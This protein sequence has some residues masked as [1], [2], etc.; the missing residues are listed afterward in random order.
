MTPIS[1]LF[2]NIYG[3]M[4]ELEK[5]DG[6]YKCAIGKSKTDRK[7]MAIKTYPGNSVVDPIISFNEEKP[8]II[9]LGYC[10]GLSSSVDIG[11]I[12]VPVESYFA[13]DSRIYRSLFKNNMVMSVDKSIKL[14]RNIT[15]ESILREISSLENILPNTSS[16]D[17]ETSY[18]YRES[19][20]LS[21]SMMI[22]SDLPLRM[23]FYTIGKTETQKIENGI[24]KSIATINSIIDV[25]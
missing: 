24:K 18:L 8:F 6:W 23:P 19:V 15:V 10:G 14:S 5:L 11:D 17:Q 21:L 7:I 22:V 12:V 9:H 3:Q 4:F 20:G 2:E 1:K 25:V 13:N 16:V